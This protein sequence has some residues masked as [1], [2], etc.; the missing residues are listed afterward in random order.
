MGNF[1]RA[2]LISAK[3][4]KWCDAGTLDAD[5]YDWELTYFGSGI[6]PTASLR[7]TSCTSIC[8]PPISPTSSDRFSMAATTTRVI[9]C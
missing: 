6:L 2:D 1:A 8:A 9:G 7:A 4:D 3:A 5:Q